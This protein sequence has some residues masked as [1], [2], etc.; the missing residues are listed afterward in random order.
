MG[1]Q[2]EP[3]P[4]LAQL[5]GNTTKVKVSYFAL[6]WLHPIN[7]AANFPFRRL[8]RHGKNKVK[9]KFLGK[10]Y[11]DGHKTG[12]IARVKRGGELK[13]LFYRAMYADN[14]NLDNLVEWAQ[15][16][17]RENELNDAGG[18]L[19][20]RKAALSIDG[21]GQHVSVYDH[22]TT[23]GKS[24]YALPFTL[25]LYPFKVI[26]NMFKPD[27]DDNELLELGRLSQL[28][29]V[30]AEG[31]LK[32]D[33]NWLKRLG[34]LFLGKY[35]NIRSDAGDVH[36]KIKRSPIVKLL[37]LGLKNVYKAKSEAAVGA[38]NTALPG[39]IDY[40]QNAGSYKD[41]PPVPVAN[42]QRFA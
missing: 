30:G 41:R 10:V 28:D 35:S 31:N 16:S 26:Y 39:I 29:G 12:L 38:M 36:T 8:G 37:T 6:P 32:L 17:P 24:V 23:F 19:D 4:G 14:D 20:T 18:L 27:N 42:I 3:A 11:H 21:L 1:H 15:D 5:V 9:H 7:W 33:E 22:N 34:T 2:E 25:P 40:V 13:G